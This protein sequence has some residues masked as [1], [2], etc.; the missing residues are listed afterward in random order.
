M[1]DNHAKD[2]FTSMLCM[3]DVC[4]GHCIYHASSGDKSDGVVHL[5]GCTCWL[6]SKQ[7]HTSVIRQCTSYPLQ[8]AMRN[9]LQ[10]MGYTRVTLSGM[11][12][13]LL[14]FLYH[15]TPALVRVQPGQPTVQPCKGGN[16]GK[17]TYVGAVSSLQDQLLSIS[18]PIS[19]LRPNL[20]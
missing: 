18:L 10:S 2:A 13:T 9:R 4:S 20:C 12:S 1:Q 7:L 14:S 19:N 3:Q 15:K 17:I 11:T 16:A 6:S 8:V 5:L